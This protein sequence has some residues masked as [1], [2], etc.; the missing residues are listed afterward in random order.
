[1]VLWELPELTLGIATCYDLRF[2]ELFRALL[3][4]GAQ[5]FVVGASWPARRAEH[6]RLRARARA[7]ENL[8][9]VLACGACGTQHGVVQAGGSLVVDPWGE[10]LADAGTTQTVLDVTIDPARVDAVRAEFPVLRDRRL[11]NRA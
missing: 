10:V 5:T 6:W 1:L 2:P 4:A 11:G 7:V 8:S 3:D 9:F